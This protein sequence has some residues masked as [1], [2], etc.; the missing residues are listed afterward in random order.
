[1]NWTHVILISYSKAEE[2]DDDPNSD[3]GKDGDGNGT[4]SSFGS[5]LMSIAATMTLIIF[6]Q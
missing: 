5:H 1:M 4:L 2:T 3:G 6:I